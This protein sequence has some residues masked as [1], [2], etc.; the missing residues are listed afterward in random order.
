VIASTAIFT[1]IATWNDFLNPLIHLH[2]EEQATP[3]VALSSLRNQYGRL[4]DVPLLTATIV[5][6][7]IPGLVLFFAAERNLVLVW[8]LGTTKR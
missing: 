2:S 8:N 5:V 4:D 3:A 7:M 6:A 1:F